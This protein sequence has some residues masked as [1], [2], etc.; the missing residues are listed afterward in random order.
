MGLICLFVLKREKSGVCS[1]ADMKGA[2]WKAKRNTYQRRVD[3]PMTKEA[4]KQR[5]RAQPWGSGGGEEA[6]FSSE[7]GRRTK[8]GSCL[9]V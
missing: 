9:H 2:V 4:E 3:N 1:Y 6:Q 5:S 7:R 8:G